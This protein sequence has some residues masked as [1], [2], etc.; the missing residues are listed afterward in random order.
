STPWRTR[1]STNIAAPLRSSDTSIPPEKS[2][3]GAIA[4]RRAA[5][6]QKLAK[7]ASSVGHAA[8]RKDMSCQ[9]QMLKQYFKYAHHGVISII[10]PWPFGRRLMAEPGVLAF[11]VLPRGDPAALARFLQRPIPAQVSGDFRDADRAHDRAERGQV[12]GQQGLD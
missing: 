1:V 12:A 9:W 11:R 2:G 6:S 3:P 10:D 4:S 8:R 7:P 5:L